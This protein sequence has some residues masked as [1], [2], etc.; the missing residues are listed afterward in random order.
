M[1]WTNCGNKQVI[2]MFNRDRK[3]LEKERFLQ[4]EEKQTNLFD[5]LGEKNE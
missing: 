1:S 4:R 2:K 3:E 5:G